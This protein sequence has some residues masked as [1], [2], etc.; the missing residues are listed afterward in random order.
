MADQ[1]EEIKAKADI[2]AVIGEHITL[3][4][5]GKNYKANCPFHGEKTPSFMVSPELQMYK[6]FGCGESG[7]IFTFLEKYEGMEFPEALKYLAD[8]VGITLESFKPGIQG[9]KE[10]LFE[11]NTLAA[12]FY[13]YILTS[14]SYGEAALSYMTKE[15]GLSLNTI[16][17]FMI[18]FAPDVVDYAKNYFVGKKQ[19]DPRDLERLG[20][21][22]FRSGKGYDRY[23]GRVVFPLF[24]HRGNVAGFTGRI[25]PGGRQDTAKYVN[26]P[27]GPTYHKSSNLFG[28]NLSKGEIKNAGYAVVVEGQMDMVSLFQGGVKNV[29]AVG[30]TALTEDQVRLLGRFTKKI[31]MSLD[32]DFAGDLAA[33]RGIIVAQKQG[34]EVRV[35]KLKDYKDPDEAIRKN[36]LVYK[37]ALD[38]AVPVWDF[39]ID[40]VFEK[41]DLSSG[42][43][44]RKVSLEIVPILTTIPDKIVQAHYVEVVAKKLGVPGS[45]VSEEVY[46]YAGEKRE[47]KVEKQII[48][49]SVEKSRRQLIEERLLT[50]AFQ[51]DPETLNRPGIRSLFST[52]LPSRI[53]EEYEKFKK[54]GGEYSPSSFA[55]VLPKELVNGFAEMVLKDIEDITSTPGQLE[56]ELEMTLHELNVMELRHKLEETG[57]KIRQYEE[58]GEK[59]KLE[60]EQRKFGELTTRLSKLVEEGKQGIILGEA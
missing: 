32:S 22:I 23:G 10:K 25:L 21:L 60:K 28:L 31:I 29:V 14:H 3:K 11:I 33:R 26:S 51:G 40:S 47:E 9:E 37:K 16:N 17:T 20:I 8:K 7:D 34:L 2:V 4:K 55:K 15:R 53:I 46:N 13:N 42:E 54:S 38:N 52:P 56:Q 5:A 35:V 6:C 57:A 43:G 1:V 18:G 50:L 19:Y 24:D 49:S 44:K 59:D 12:R 58:E 45:A 30:G 41:V 39:I 27:E 36:P 48:A